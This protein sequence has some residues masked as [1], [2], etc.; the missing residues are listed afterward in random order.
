M[1]PWDYRWK[2]FKHQHYLNW[3]YW[4][5]LNHLSWKAYLLLWLTFYHYI[6]TRRKLELLRMFS[7]HWWSPYK[8]KL[9]RVRRKEKH[10]SYK[11]R[12]GSII[13]SVS[14]ISNWVMFRRLSIIVIRQWCLIRTFQYFIFIKPKYL[15]L[16]E[17]ELKLQLQQS[18]PANSTRKIVN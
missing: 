5:I 8:R 13:F 14:I 6:K 1:H 16:R 2:L 4:I 15:N 10:W 9:K 18:L 7:L 12:A 3:N 17:T 11:I